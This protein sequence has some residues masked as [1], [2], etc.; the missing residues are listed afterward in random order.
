MAQRMSYSVVALPTMNVAILGLFKRQLF[1]HYMAVSKIKRS[2]SG[3]QDTI[4]TH[5]HGTTMAIICI[6]LPIS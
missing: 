6:M 3:L 4:L 1:G 2:G 5:G